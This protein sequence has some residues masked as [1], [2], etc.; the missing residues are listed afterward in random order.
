MFN[1]SMVQDRLQKKLP[2]TPEFFIKCVNY[3]ILNENL[4][5]SE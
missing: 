2:L 3:Q 4:A 1:E 5:P